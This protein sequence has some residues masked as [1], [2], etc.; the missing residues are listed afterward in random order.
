MVA[1]DGESA[2]LGVQAM[3]ALNQG[4]LLPGEAPR[5]GKPDGAAIAPELHGTVE[6]TPG[7]CTFDQFGDDSPEWSWEI[8]G[9]ITRVGD[10]YD[11]AIDYDV[12]VAPTHLHWRMDGWMTVTPTRIDG[13]IHVAADGETDGSSIEWDVTVIYNAILLDVNGCAVGGS[14]DARSI[15]SSAGRTI[16]DLEGIVTF[17]PACGEVH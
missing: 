8:D 13:E 4:I 5:L 3:I 9:T 14:I 12:T 15:F 16:F 10:R 7:G 1:Q 2:A 6:C 11:F 17:G